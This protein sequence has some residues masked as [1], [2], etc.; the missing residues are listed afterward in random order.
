MLNSSKNDQKLALLTSVFFFVFFI[1]PLNNAEVK[2]NVHRAKNHHFLRLLENICF[3]T[4]V[5]PLNSAEVHNCRQ[6]KTTVLKVIKFCHCC[7]KI[8]RHCCKTPQ[9]H[10][11]TTLPEKIKYVHQCLKTIK[12]WPFCITFVVVL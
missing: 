10:R 3:S 2:K 9:K 6:K 1:L 11:R 5:L 12:N 7:T 4:V 8:F